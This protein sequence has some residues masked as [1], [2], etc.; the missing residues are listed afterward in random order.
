[1]LIRRSA[2][3]THWYLRD[4]KP[5]YEVQKK[6][7]TGPR[8]AHVGDAFKAGAYRSV[9]NV[10]GV[11]GKPG[12]VKWQI[13]QAILSSLT[14]PRVMNEN[15]HEFAERVIVDSESQTRKAAELGTLMH[16]YAEDFLAGGQLP[17]PTTD[18][19]L[20]TPFFK[21]VGANVNSVI[22][23]EVVVVNH[24]HAYAGKLDA[25]V[26][27]KDGTH[28]IIDIKSKDVAVD[29]RG[30]PK[31]VFYDEWAMQLAAYAYAGVPGEPR[32]DWKLISIILN[33]NIDAAE[34]AKGPFIKEWTSDRERHMRGFIAA[35]DLWTY[36]KGGIPGKD[37]K[38]YKAAA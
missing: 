23:S 24:E 3:S 37:A 38:A 31:P 32:D 17:K 1:M 8:P 5:F 22:A 21:W 27:L 2:E 28:A 9:T 13:E 34:S 30:L 26:E 14:L 12:L 18:Q 20:M 6:D 36:Q 7:G 33:R 4:G 10:L 11:I 25:A 29:V 15:E 19:I 35:C 16:A